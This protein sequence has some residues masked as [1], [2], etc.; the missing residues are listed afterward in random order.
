[1][2]EIEAS[3]AEA[4]SPAQTSPRLWDEQGL[5]WCEGREKKF[6]LLIILIRNNNPHLKADDESFQLSGFN[7]QE[8]LHCDLFPEN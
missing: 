1:V 3:F 6:K 4:A 2:D 8:S 5:K 7:F